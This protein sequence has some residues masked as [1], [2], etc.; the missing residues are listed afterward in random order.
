[1]TIATKD[2]NEKE[3]KQKTRRL[4]FYERG[5]RMRVGRFNY[6]DPYSCFEKGCP[7]K[8]KS[9]RDNPER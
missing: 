5:R 2:E 6:D 4:V 8:A 3:Q 7:K 9:V 1:M